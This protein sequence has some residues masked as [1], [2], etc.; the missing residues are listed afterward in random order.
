MDNIAK[1]QSLCLR[2]NFADGTLRLADGKL[3][4]A[5]RAQSVAFSL[6]S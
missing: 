2:R 5:L 4:L 1:L 3:R 6:F